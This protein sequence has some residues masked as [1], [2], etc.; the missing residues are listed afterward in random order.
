MQRITAAKASLNGQVWNNLFGKA[1]KSAAKQRE[2]S[3]IGSMMNNMSDTPL[4]FKPPLVLSIRILLIKN[5]YV[6]PD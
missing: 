4:E 5:A 2:M 3:I 6:P 1:H